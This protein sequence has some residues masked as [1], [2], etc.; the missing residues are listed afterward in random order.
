MFYIYK[1]VLLSSCALVIQ[2]LG[3]WFVTF[4]FGSCHQIACP[5]VAQ[6]PIHLHILLLSKLED[7]SEKY[8][9]VMSS[10]S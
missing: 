10:S 5:L 1:L 7:I 8:S 9:I 2:T 3:H 6:H 4:S